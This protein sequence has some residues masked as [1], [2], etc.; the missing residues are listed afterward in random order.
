MAR[1]RLAR[2]KCCGAPIHGNPTSIVFFTRIGDRFVDCEDDLQYSTINSV[3]CADCA[4]A[5]NAVLC[6]NDFAAGGG[7][8][9]FQRSYAKRGGSQR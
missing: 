4:N 2:C 8:V 1:P 7:G 9:R 6:G 5:I 3:F